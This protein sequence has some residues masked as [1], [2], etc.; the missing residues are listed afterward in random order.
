MDSD[1]QKI[2]DKSKKL[3][4]VIE[5]PAKKSHRQKSSQPYDYL[6][7]TKLVKFSGFHKIMFFIVFPATLCV[8]FLFPGYSQ[9]VVLTL[10]IYGTLLVVYALINFLR[11]RF[12]F[13][14]WKERLR[15]GLT[16]WDEM[17]R[18]KKMYCDLCWN[19]V[20]ISIRLKTEEPEIFKLIEAS[21]K[22]FCKKTELAFYDEKF[23]SH[24]TKSRNSWK[25]T[26]RNTA[27]GSANP[28]V[29]KYMKNLFQSELNTIAAKTGQIENVVVEITSEEFEIPIEIRSGD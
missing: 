14:G 15:F 20:K 9:T 25:L 29:M 21:L 8:G 6:V 13:I 27:E 19:N 23:D 7:F 28:E 4:P 12:I 1:L 2:L 17:I 3:D 18:T 24:G 11:Y 5:I 22:I 16:G 26:S 10:L